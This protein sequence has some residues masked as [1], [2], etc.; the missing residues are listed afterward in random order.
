M[1]EAP[2]SDSRAPAPLRVLHLED[3]RADAELIQ[4]ALDADDIPIEPLRVD[5]REDYVAALQRGGFELIL[6][7]YSLPGFDGISALGLAQEHAPE[8]PF[9]F[10]SATLGEELATETLKR[11]ATDYVL[12]QRLSRLGPAVRR[13]MQEVQQRREQ[14]RTEA[15][16]RERERQLQQAHKMEALGRLAGG[17][18]HDF[19]N[20]LTVIMGYAQMV[21]NELDPSHPLA[22]KMIETQKAGTRAAQL[23]RQL[24]A[25]SRQQ[26]MAPRVIDVNQV[27]EHLR[28]MLTR[29]IGEHIE[30]VVEQDPSIG[31]VKADPGQLEQVIMNLVA[32]ARD[33]MAAGGT[34]TVRTATRHLADA[35]RSDRV[36]LPGGSYVT[37]SVTDTGC[38]MDEQ[39]QAEIFEPFFTTK[40][41]GRGTGLGLSVVHGIVTQSGGG[42][43]VRSVRGR[44]TTFIVYLPCTEEPE[45]EETASRQPHGRLHGSETVLLVEDDLA[46]RA[47]IRDE[48]VQRGYQVLD[49]GSVAEALLINSHHA[50][51][52]H[53]LL[54]DVV[55][56]GMSG[57][58]LAQQLGLLRPNIRVLYVSGYT[59][60]VGVTKMLGTSTAAFLQK[61]FSQAALAA[62][63]REVLDLPG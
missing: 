46:V 51:P 27:V 36:D 35:D 47:V 55:L 57:R 31:R 4:A 16:L 37:L 9:L 20:C 3:S 33:A 5:T 2:P 60:D 32:N 50:G 42:I 53:L 23:I 18:A 45:T 21:L 13:A 15:M 6:A 40:A 52:I 29:L 25:F 30:F 59:D 28:G 14:R 62:K 41:E 11:G 54:T 58:E 38:G 56:P 49:A 61:P 10:I 44:G 63:V 43:E 8:V 1:S 34:L 24:L 22:G 17:V 48:L 39:T 7:D 26:P 12:K 19:N